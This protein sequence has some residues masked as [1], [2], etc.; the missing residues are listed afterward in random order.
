[1]MQALN[2]SGN[3]VMPVGDSPKVLVSPSNVSITQA[4]PVIHPS[5]PLLQSTSIGDIGRESLRQLGIPSID[6]K[7]N[8]II[9][10]SQSTCF[11]ISARP[12]PPTSTAV[13]N[14]PFFS[15]DEPIQ[16]GDVTYCKRSEGLYVV[17]RDMTSYR[18]W[19]E[20]A[21]T[22]AILRRLDTAFDGISS[23][24]MIVQEFLKILSKEKGNRSLPLVVDWKH[25]YKP[26]SKWATS[27]KRIR[28]GISYIKFGFN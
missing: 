15:G 11:E 12:N 23:K 19:G 26:R 8:V 18:A 7:P 4:K 14:I 21:S 16:I 24:G 2:A 20:K 17:G 6:T 9:D 5:T 10:D 22:K 28:K 13:P 27:E 3:V 25:F 1:M